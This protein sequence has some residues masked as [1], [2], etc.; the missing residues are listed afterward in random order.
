MISK[1]TYLTVDD[2]INA[3]HCQLPVLLVL[4]PLLQQPRDH[5]HSACDTT[6]Q[7]V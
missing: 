3:S 7:S 5:L 2:G 6:Q 4:L 1:P